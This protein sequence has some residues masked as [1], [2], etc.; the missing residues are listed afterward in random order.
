MWNCCGSSKRHGCSTPPQL[1]EQASAPRLA[2]DFAHLSPKPHHQAFLFVCF[3]CFVSS[4]PPAK[5]RT[6]ASPYSR[7]QLKGSLVC[8]LRQ[9]SSEQRTTHFYLLNSIQEG[10]LSRIE[11]HAPNVFNK[12]F[13]FFCF[14]GLVMLIVPNEL[15][16]IVRETFHFFLRA[17]QP[18]S[19]C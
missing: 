1:S 6:E 14:A 9:A 4:L 10:I 13:L 16:Q 8:T 19:C 11:I 5:S 15:A 18:S 17:L 12:C 2:P 3:I 7:G